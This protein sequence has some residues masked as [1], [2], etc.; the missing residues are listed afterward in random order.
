MEE[1]VGWGWMEYSVVDRS[2]LG[3]RSLEKGGMNYV[4]NDNVSWVAARRWG[5]VSTSEKTTGN[6]SLF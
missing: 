2:L 6:S 4:G 5:S 3:E 1:L